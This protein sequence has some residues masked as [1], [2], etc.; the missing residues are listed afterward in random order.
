MK[1][2]PKHK[3]FL[4]YDS[5]CIDRLPNLSLPEQIAYQVVRSATAQF[6]GYDKPLADMAYWLRASEFTARRALRTLVAA[7]LLEEVIANGKATTYRTRPLAN[8]NPLQIA[9]PCKLQPHPLQIAT[10]I[11]I[12][13]IDNNRENIEAAPK[14]S[15]FQKPTIEQIAA[16]CQERQNGIDAEA[17]FYF[18]E[19]KGWLVGKTP[20][21]DWQAAVRTWEQKRKNETQH[22]NNNPR[23][24]AT[25][26]ANP[27]E[28]KPYSRIQ[29]LGNTRFDLK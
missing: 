23:Q 15:K 18:Y 9:T 14:K 2:Q 11:I 21:K 17:F 10:P 7:G 20:M 5:E 19:S 26:A 22:G 28:A 8:C 24:A 12:D 29:Q 13:N 4:K 27:T 1:T 25:T 16:Y 3:G 6:G